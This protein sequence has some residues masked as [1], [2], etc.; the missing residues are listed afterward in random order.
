MSLLRKI[1]NKE[2]DVKKFRNFVIVEFVKSGIHCI[3][4][5]N[6]T[7]YVLYA[8]KSL[9]NDPTWEFSKM[10]YAKLSIIAPINANDNDD[11]H[12]AITSNMPCIPPC[13]F[14]NEG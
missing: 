7:C 4:I 13:S 9:L 14:T 6:H 2:I 10:K 3:F 1:G 11:L 8:D 12:A 5:C